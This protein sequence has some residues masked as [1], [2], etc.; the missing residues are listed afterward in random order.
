MTIPADAQLAAL[1]RAV[2]DNPD[3]REAVET[4]IEAAERASTLTRQLLLFSRRQVLAPADVA[5]AP[6]VHAIEKMLRRLVPEDVEVRI[7]A[8]DPR[9]VAS[10]DPGQLD[11]VVLNLVAN[12]RDA[13]PQGGVLTLTVTGIT[14]AG[15]VDVS[16]ERAVAG[17]FVRLSVSDTGAGIDNEVRDHIFEPFFS[18]K[19]AGKGTGLG[20]ATVYGIVKSGGGYIDV[21][22]ERGRGT[23]IDVYF[24]SAGS[25][26]PVDDITQTGRHGA[27]GHETVLVAEDDGVVRGLIQRTLTHAGYTVIT[28]VDGTEACLLAE[29]H[30]APIDLLL[31]DLVMP[32]MNGQQLL[33]Q[34]R[35]R[36]PGLRAMFLT[37][38]TD[39]A[40]V[41]AEVAD[42]SARLLRKPCRPRTLLHAVRECLD[43][44]G[45]RPG[46][47][48]DRR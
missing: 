22:S 23:T 20:L 14:T 40:V 25:G 3:G 7:V 6:A 33:A 32:Q 4:I 17:D 48:G 11:Q 46:D 30:G 28:A 21:Q 1:A 19:A 43:D 10:V 38:H 13:M 44:T 42:P 9:L 2:A 41:D 16:G 12:A 36:H 5:I 45:V 35:A 27:V 29:A 15:F 47:A 37:A 26:S 18:T 34:L 24:P 31:S 39:H 8:E